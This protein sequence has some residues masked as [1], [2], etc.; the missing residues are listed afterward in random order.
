MAGVLGI[1]TVTAGLSTAG[2]GLG[3]GAWEKVLREG[4]PAQHLKFALA[5]TGG[6]GPFGVAIH[7]AVIMLQELPRNKR[8]LRARK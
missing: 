3:Q 6:I 5:E 2:V 7:L 1:G 8:N 4:E